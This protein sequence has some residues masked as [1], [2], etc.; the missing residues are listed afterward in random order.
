MAWSQQSSFV[1]ELPRGQATLLPTASCVLVKT[2]DFK[3]PFGKPMMRPY[4][5]VS[6][7][8]LEGELT[9]L[10]KKYE[11]GN[12]SKYIH[13]LKPGDK[14]AIKGPMPKWQWKSVLYPFRYL[15]VAQ[16]CCSER[17]CRGWPHC[18]GHWNVRSLPNILW[19]N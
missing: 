12:V 4:T 14:V 8:D 17:I 10:I 11:T 16:L 1:F 7:S 19:P 18:R 5:P 15:I 6:P 3:D 2:E 9:L 13:S